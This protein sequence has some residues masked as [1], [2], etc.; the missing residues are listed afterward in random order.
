MALD[1]P[2][3]AFD[4]GYPA[5]SKGKRYLPPVE[6]ETP[7]LEKKCQRNYYLIHY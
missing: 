1:D 6:K 7:N 3:L 2:W 5:I 4:A